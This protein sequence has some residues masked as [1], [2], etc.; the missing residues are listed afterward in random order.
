MTDT[1]AGIATILRR[2]LMDIGRQRWVRIS[3]LLQPLLFVPLFFGLPGL[4]AQRSATDLSH[5]SVVVAVQGG[6]EPVRQALESGGITIRE[7]RDAAAAVLGRKA[8][9]GMVVSTT[10]RG[11]RAPE[12]NVEVLLLGASG[13]SVLAFFRVQGVLNRATAVAE[14]RREV[15]IHTTDL[16]R[17][18]AGRRFFA[19]SVLPVYVWFPL[20]VMLGFSVSTLASE[21]DGRT[22]ESLLVLPYRPWQVIAAKWGVSML[23]ALTVAAV[24]LLPF[25]VVSVLD[26]PA[27]GGRLSFGWA[28]LSSLSI[29]MFAVAAFTVSAGLAV[30]AWGTSAREASSL[31]ASIYIPAGVMSVIF[32]VVPDISPAPALLAVPVLGPM[33]LARE[34]ILGPLGIGAILSVLLPTIVYSTLLVEAARRLTSGERAILRPQT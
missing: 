5:G 22:L 14:R 32:L 15:N 28:E 27:L 18:P 25:A 17:S 26:L 24:S 10:L 8:D 12:L 20:S 33:I 19:A 34:G 13:K 30:G 7:T 1:P 2:E 31:S 6:A 21:K 23:A 29:A 4:I 9:V 3:T 11:K 16:V